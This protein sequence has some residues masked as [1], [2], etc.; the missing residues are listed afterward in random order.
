V[1]TGVLILNWNGWRDTLECLET[2]FRL[3]GLEGPV[4]V[5]D[6]DSRDGSIERI[7]AWARGRQAADEPAGGL[8][9]LTAA[10]LPRPIATVEYD[11]ARAEAG[12]TPSD[13]N[14][15]LVLIRTGGNLGFAGGNNVG[16]RYALARGDLES[17]WL[18]NNDT[19]VDPM[20]LQHLVDAMRAEPSM[21]ICGSTLMEYADPRRVQARGGGTFNA[22][23]ALPRFIGAGERR[24]DAPADPRGVRRRLAYVTGASMLVSRRFLETVGLLDEGYFLYF[25]E[26]DWALRAGGRFTLGYAPDSVVYH[27]EGRSIGTHGG[28]EKSLLSDRYFMRNRLLLTR[29]YFP[30]RLATVRLALLVSLLRRA[31]RGQWDRVR[32][33]AE[34]WRT[35]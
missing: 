32:L 8:Q 23:L 20:A 17:V 29:K 2:V 21:G 3:R 22:W 7:H 19:V 13:A 9:E 31:A 14:A 28:R 30:R 6:N 1:R 11:R 12:G 15:P 4:I 10:P 27:K 24:L 16:L 26:L 25:E 18:L 33:I 5:C 34:L 35:G